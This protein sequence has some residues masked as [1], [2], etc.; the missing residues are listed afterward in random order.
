LFV[1]TVLHSFIQGSGKSLTFQLVG[2][3][4]GKKNY[5]EIG[6][7]ELKSTFNEY[8]VDKQFVL[9]DEITNRK[10]LRIATESLKRMITRETVEINSKYLRQYTVA[11]RVNWG[12]TSNH[13]DA[14]FVNG[15]DRR[16]FIW[17]VAGGELPVDMR[18]RIIAWRDSGDA[19]S[20]LRWY[21]ENLDLSGFDPAARAPD[22]S[23]KAEAAFANKTG[24]EMSI[25]E[26]LAVEPTNDPTGWAK[27][28]LFTLDAIHNFVGRGE[29][30]RAVAN[31]LA[32]RGAPTL[33][34]TK[35]NGWPLTLVA[36]RNDER[37]K[38]ASHAERM[39]EYK[40]CHKEPKWSA[41]AHR[42][43]EEAR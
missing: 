9:G 32:D 33:P 17:T 3:V 7:E 1:A 25:D 4:Y 31:H 26:L 27:C 24:L 42:T 13:R 43:D 16:F 21:F 22:T 39:A 38:A 11:D 20:A 15:P 14:V 2:R 29:S 30:K 41:A 5:A 6:S 37:W 28:D 36:I 23:A 19:A 40:R 35:V 12:L 8:I 10:D 34:L 18:D